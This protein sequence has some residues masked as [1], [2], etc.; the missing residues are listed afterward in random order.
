MG[1]PQTFVNSG[2]KSNAY[3]VLHEDHPAIFHRHHCGVEFPTMG[4][5]GRPGINP[6]FYCP[7]HENPDPTNGSLFIH[8]ERS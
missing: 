1:K 5:R 8:S 2:N 7:C 4:E 6:Y 3:A